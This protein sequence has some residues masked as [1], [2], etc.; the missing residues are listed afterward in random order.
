MGRRTTYTHGTFCWVDLSTPDV[1]AADAFYERVFGWSAEELPAGGYWIFERGDDA[2]AG[3]APLTDV[4]MQSGMHQGWATYV[5]VEDADAAAA[6][7]TQLGGTVTTQPFEIEGAGRMA[8]I[9]DPQGVPLL[10][11]QAGAFPGASLVN[12]VGAWCWNDL[13][14]PDPEAASAFY[15]ELLGWDI[16]EVPGS[17]GQYW[18][19]RNDDRPNGGIMPLPPGAE[20][21]S[22]NVYFGVESVGA[23]FE[24]VEAAGGAR[25][26]GPI[27][28]PAG[29]FG[30]ATD[31][32]GATFCLFE[33]EY[34]E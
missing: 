5:C 33:G 21:P 8:A 24:H 19:V 15:S 31:P 2:L 9:A 4:Q 3:L 26:A 25:V 29:R 10:L 17:G 32:L 22:W 13:Q 1:E 6:R 30:V 11:W 16:G 18:F 12:G 14:T 27:D 23:T 7:V 34:D 28:V 20:G